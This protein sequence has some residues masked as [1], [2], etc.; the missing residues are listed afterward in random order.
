MLASFAK[1]ELLSGLQLRVGIASN[2]LTAANS[3]NTYDVSPQ[4]HAAIDSWDS[5]KALFKRLLIIVELAVLTA[6]SLSVKLYDDEETITTGT[7]ADAQLAFTLTSMTAAGLYAAEIRLDHVFPKTSAR[8]IVTD[9]ESGLDDNVAGEIQR[10]HSIRA[11]A[12]GG[13]ATFSVLCLYGFSLRGFPRAKHTV[14]TPT[15]NDA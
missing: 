10:Y 9:A 7:A 1:S 13:D 4:P 15:F 5:G 2:T 11:T 6:G 14:L 3:I 8:Y 12:T